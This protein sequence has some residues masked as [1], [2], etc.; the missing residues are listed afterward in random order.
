V[1]R[2][3]KTVF[4][5][6]AVLLFG[7]CIDLG[8]GPPEGGSA[9]DESSP[10]CSDCA[11]HALSGDVRL[12]VNGRFTSPQALYQSN[13]PSDDDGEYLGSTI[14]IYDPDATCDDGTTAC[15]LAVLLHVDWRA[16][17]ERACAELGVDVGGVDFR[18]TAAQIVAPSSTSWTPGGPAL[19]EVNVSP[20]LHVHALPTVGTSRPVYD[21]FVAYCV[22]QPGAPPPCAIVRAG[23][24]A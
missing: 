13:L 3:V 12:F 10:W 18:M 24:G 20:A 9:G 19:L 16:A 8:A 21:A 7:G 23:R 17:A 1:P 11:A 15:R 5:F 14:Y 22:Q 4:N 6:A 2:E